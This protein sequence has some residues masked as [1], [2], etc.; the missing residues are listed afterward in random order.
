VE[1][2]EINGKIYLVE[3]IL[4]SNRNAWARLKG[5]RIVISL[6][7]RWPSHEKEKTAVGLLKR[8]IKA[9]A[10]GRWGCEGTKKIEFHHG[11]RLAA[12]GKEY[13]ISL[14]PS[15]RFGKR[16]REGGIEVRVDERHPRKNEKAA[17]LVRKA[18][19]EAL[20]PHL[21]ERVSDI[22]SAH[23][24]SEITK[25]TVRDSTTRWGSCGRDGSISLNFRLLFMPQGI[26]DYVIVH[27]LAHTKYRGHGPRFWGLVERVMPDHRERRR[28]LKENGWS[29]PRTDRNA[30]QMTLTECDEPY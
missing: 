25:V 4:S 17:S 1:S 10:K 16:M 23:F 30:G 29:Y 22:N 12:F 18:L 15:K 24:R 26:L 28:W 2:I 11:Q 7:S 14:M 13:E 19:T 5:E 8:A 20:M 27:E 21:I 3:R 6:P 9:I